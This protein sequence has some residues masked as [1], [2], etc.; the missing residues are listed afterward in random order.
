MDGPEFMARLMKAVGADMPPVIMCTC[1]NQQESIIKVIRDGAMGYIVKPF[2]RNTLQMQL[3][4]LGIVMGKNEDAELLFATE[5]TD[6]KKIT[7]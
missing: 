2:S 5:K 3:R 7:F 6:V 4:Q 1:E